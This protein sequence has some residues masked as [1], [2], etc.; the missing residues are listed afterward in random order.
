M[1]LAKFGKGKKKKVA[2]KATS[3]YSGVT[4]AED[5]DPILEEG[6]HQCKVLG[7]EEFEGEKKGGTYFKATLEIIESSTYDAGEVRA[8]LQCVTKGNALR[9]GGPKVMSFVQAAAG[10][11]DFDDFCEDKGGAEEAAQF[12]DACGGG[13]DACETFGEN[14]LEDKIVNVRVTKNGPPKVYTNDKGEE[15]E[16]QYYNY[17]WSAEA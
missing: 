3:K 17:A 4:P 11:D 13:E 6:L 15:N 10:F 14:P 9:V 16:V 1:G 2:K 7:T 8:F 5:R 12:V